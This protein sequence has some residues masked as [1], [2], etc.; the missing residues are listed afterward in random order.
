MS[1]S[2]CSCDV[3][4]CGPNC[5]CTE[6]LCRCEASS[7]L[8]SLGMSSPSRIPVL[9]LDDV[10]AEWNVKNLTCCS[11]KKIESIFHED[12]N[13]K[14]QTNAQDVRVDATAGTI[15]AAVKGQTQADQLTQKMSS[16][17]FDVRLVRVGTCEADY[18]GS[19]ELG[20]VDPLATEGQKLHR[21]QIE[22]GNPK[23]AELAVGG[24]TCT[25]CSQTVRSALKAI[26]GVVTAS[27]AL[28]TTIARI[29][30]HESPTCNPSRMKD[31]IEDVGFTVSLVDEEKLKSTSPST[32]PGYKVVEFAVGGMTCSMCSNAIQNALSEISTVETVSVSLATNIARI[33]F[34]ET[35]TSTV[36][37][38]KET[39]EDI[40]YSVDDVMYQDD[41]DMLQSEESAND[42]DPQDR[43]QRLL[44]I[45]EDNVGS[46]KLAFI[47]SLAGAFPI[48]LL[49]MVIPH[50]L[51]STSVL[52]KLLAKQVNIF[53][54]SFALEALVLWA[55]ATPVQFGSG[56]S[57]YKVSRFI[58]SL[59][60]PLK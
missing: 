13:G 47:W 38:L 8:N 11:K 1:K 24:M 28:A 26:P 50:V 58:L 42:I 7:V 32:V 40:G 31:A 34:K 21:K 15:R 35:P 16:A 45:Q 37:V 48:L 51:P 2:C 27:V 10:M 54:H 49:T 36:Q 29:E 41:L 56:Y 43:L 9:G 52:R 55:L 12:C 60:V 59:C 33:E 25:M 5:Q 57:F 20:Y 46:K 4:Y 53:G 30:Y 17:G 23:I 44:R 19:E 22:S 6:A 18:E 14:T 39:I 3:C